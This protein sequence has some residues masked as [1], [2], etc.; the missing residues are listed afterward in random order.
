MRF[1]K[2][3]SY[4]RVIRPKR[5]QHNFLLFLCFSAVIQTFGCRGIKNTSSNQ[6]EQRRSAVGGDLNP[7]GPGVKPEIPVFVKK[8]ENTTPAL[9]YTAPQKLCFAKGTAVAPGKIPEAFQRNCSSCHGQDGKGIGDF[10]NLTS[11]SFESLQS[12][13]RSGK[14]TK[15]PAFNAAW[16]S[17]GD[18]MQL[19]ATMQSVTLTSTEEEN[20]DTENAAVAKIPEQSFEEIQRKGIAALRKP[21]AD[22]L[23]C[24]QCHAP[25]AIDMAYVGFDEGTILRRALMHVATEDAKDIVRYVTVQRINL[26]IPVNDP[27]TF[28]PFQPGGSPLNCTSNEDCDHQFGLQLLSAAPSL[29]TPIANIAA[30]R[31][32]RDELLA[33][34]PRTFKIGFA[35]NRWTEDSFHGNENAT[36]R[37]WIPNFTFAPLTVAAREKQN[38]V[39]DAYLKNPDWVNLKAMI[40]A[41]KVDSAFSPDVKK[42]QRIYQDKLASV[43]VASHLFRQEILGKESFQDLPPVLDYGVLNPFWGVADG[44]RTMMGGCSE[45]AGPLCKEPPSLVVTEASAKNITVVDELDD[46]RLSW[47]WAGWQFDQTLYR[48]PSGAAPSSEY[49]TGALYQRRHFNHLLYMRW[50]KNFT[51]AYRKGGMVSANGE[52]QLASP[53]GQNWGYFFGYDRGVSDNSIPPDGEKRDLYR[54]L[55]SN[56][57]RL[58]YWLLLDEALNLK[59]I[60]TKADIVKQATDHSN[61]SFL[62]NFGSTPGS[63]QRTEDENLLSALLDGVGKA[64]ENRAL[65]YKE[66]PPVGH[67]KHN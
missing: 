4:F 56:M 10:P 51:A 60:D 2:N 64:C 62:L 35:M 36:G 40:E 25:D 41:K 49:F 26:K 14:G 57:I 27:R 16:I 20:C 9:L 59:K 11:I 42:W 46:I 5:A 37:E 43:E 30:A 24:A 7:T 23:S 21:D 53:V 6:I 58:N 55:A 22:G 29:A 48:T 54:K 1:G 12:I 38:G 13:V 67:C 8:N 47:F 31:K 63:T 66:E 3:E 15:M 17:S 18:L 44:A 61:R 45:A 33:I 34:N 65:S 28:R 19:S 52:Q 32:A 39:M 50:L